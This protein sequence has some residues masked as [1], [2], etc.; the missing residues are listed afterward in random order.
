MLDLCTF[1]N[2]GVAQMTTI[3]RIWAAVNE[4]EEFLF[5]TYLLES[6]V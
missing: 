2:V 6:M 5:N 4:N 1:G 3:R